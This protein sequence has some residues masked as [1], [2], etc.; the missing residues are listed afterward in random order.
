VEDLVY[1]ASG[2]DEAFMA[3][4][5]VDSFQPRDTGLEFRFHLVV[6]K[7]EGERMLVFV[8]PT[9]EM[10]LVVAVVFIFDV[11]AVVAVDVV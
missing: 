1:P 6:G 10:D 5:I 8:A 11:D 3:F 2:L 4:V 9:S 7:P